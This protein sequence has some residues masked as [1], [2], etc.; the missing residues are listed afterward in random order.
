MIKSSFLTIFK[1]SILS[2]PQRLRGLGQHLLSPF[3][4]EGAF[5]DRYIPAKNLG[6]WFLE[7]PF[8][9]ADVLLIP[10]VYQLIIIGFNYKKIRTLS[11]REISAARMIFSDAIDLDIVRINEKARIGEKVALAYVA[12][13]SVFAFRRLSVDVLMHELVHVWQFQ[14]FGSVYIVKA[15]WAQNS[16]EGYKYGD[17]QG[18]YKAMMGGKRFI[19]FNFEQQGDIVQDYYLKFIRMVKFDD[20]TLLEQST[21]EYF[22]KQLA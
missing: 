12:F 9:L 6:L 16:K 20:V 4:K 1:S 8:Y 13:N 17:A 22:I 2:Y 7:L 3:V 10:M 21:Y 5:R 18:L 15:L 19:D 14:K 11:S